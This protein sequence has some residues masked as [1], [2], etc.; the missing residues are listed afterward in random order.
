MPKELLTPV[1]VLVESNIWEYETG[2]DV[3]VDYPHDF[4]NDRTWRC[5]GGVV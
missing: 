5:G 3:P 4:E 2:Y 1:E